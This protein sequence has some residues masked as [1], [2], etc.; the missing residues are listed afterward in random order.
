MRGDSASLAA[1]DSAKCIG[2][3]MWRPLG[4]QGPIE[5]D[6]GIRAM[7]LVELSELPSLIRSRTWVM[8]V[9]GPCVTCG[10]PKL[11]V[12][13]T[14]LRQPPHLITD[15][16]CDSQTARTFAATLRADQ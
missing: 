8:L 13:Q 15:L 14:L 11:D 12:M 4:T 10:A 1:L 3:L 5:L 9:L 16:V 2:D 7:T 6:A